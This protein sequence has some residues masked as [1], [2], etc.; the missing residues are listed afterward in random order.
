MTLND[1][2]RMRIKFIRAYKN[3]PDIIILSSDDW[4]GLDGVYGER[5]F[6]M[7]IQLG[8]K[9]ECAFYPAIQKL[10]NYIGVKPRNAETF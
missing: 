7:E 9:S 4:D 10:D 5:I 1:I 3:I 2:A 6:G 8:N